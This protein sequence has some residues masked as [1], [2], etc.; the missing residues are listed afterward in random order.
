MDL[1]KT[2]DIADMIANTIRGFISMLKLVT[3][4]VEDVDGLQ[5]RK[6]VRPASAEVIY[7][8]AARLLVKLQKKRSDV[9]TVNLVAHLLR[10]VAVNRVRLPFDG[11]E[12]D[13]T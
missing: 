13:V 7:F 4:R 5:N 8:T 2:G 11:A 10:L 1:F 12:H 9:V 6:A 3:H